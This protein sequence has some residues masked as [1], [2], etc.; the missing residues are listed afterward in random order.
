MGILERFSDY[1]ERQIALYKRMLKEQPEIIRFLTEDNL[2]AA[3][4]LSATHARDSAA[5]EQE[6][7]VL[8]REWQS[9]APSGNG[10]QGVRALATEAAALAEQL[11]Q[12]V[13]GAAGQTREKRQAVRREWE[14]IRRGQ[15]VID[16]YRTMDSS[17][18]DRIDRRA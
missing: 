6:F 17:E 3:E 9:K 12:L 16:R 10:H 7:G 18:P 11:E 8:L 15:N 14:A 1:F 5:L 2:D 13:N 4:A